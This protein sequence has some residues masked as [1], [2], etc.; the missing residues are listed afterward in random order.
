MSG[1]HTI[2]SVHVRQWVPSRVGCAVA[3]RKGGLYAMV[4]L[5]NRPQA[6]TGLASDQPSHSFR[7]EPLRAVLGWLALDSRRP[8]R[9]LSTGFVLGGLGVALNVGIYAAAG[10]YRI[11]SVHVDLV[12]LLVAG[13]L[14]YLWVGVYEEL[15]VRGVG[16]RLLERGFGTTAALVISSLAFGLLHLSNPGATLLGALETGAAAGVLLGA[17]YLLTRNLW[18]AIGIHWAADFW[19]GAVFGLHPAGTSFAHPL[20]HATLSGPRVWT[21]DTYGGGLIGLAIGGGAAVILVV[22]AARRGRFHRGWLRLHRH[23][24]APIS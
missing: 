15:L 17:A 14:G 22:L 7:Q 16:F 5:T 8:L 2:V 21:G 18:L 11:Q 1:A 12:P 4:H 10:W 23:H 19:Q 20:L 24:A 6:T 13:L 3:H 9:D